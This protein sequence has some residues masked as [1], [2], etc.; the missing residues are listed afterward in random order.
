MSRTRTRNDLTGLPQ[1]LIILWTLAR[2]DLSESS[3]QNIWAQ[4]AR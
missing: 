4:L 3:H 1:F 2:I